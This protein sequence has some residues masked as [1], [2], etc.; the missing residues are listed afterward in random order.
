MAVT[1]TGKTADDIVMVNATP[2]HSP[3]ALQVDQLT[4]TARKHAMQELRQSGGASLAMDPTL[5]VMAMGSVV[6]SC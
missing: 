5:T 6:N 2:A 4:R 3:N 1:M